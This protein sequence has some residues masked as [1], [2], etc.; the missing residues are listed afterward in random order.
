MLQ[1]KICNSSK[2][3]IEKEKEQFVVAY[4]ININITKNNIVV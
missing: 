3:Q 1:H 4:L 2:V